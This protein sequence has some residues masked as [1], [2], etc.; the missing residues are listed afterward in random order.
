MAVFFLCVSLASCLK[1]SLNYLPFQT[2]FSHITIP[3]WTFH[4]AWGQDGWMLA[5]VFFFLHFFGQRKSWGPQ[6][7]KNRTRLIFSHLCQTSLVSKES[8]ILQRFCALTQIKND[9]FLLRAGKESQLC[10]WHNEPTRFVF[11]FFILT[12]FCYFLLLHCQQC[13]RIM[14]IVF[15]F[16]TISFLSRIKAGNP[17]PCSLK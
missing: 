17:E 4:E 2:H 12:V 13:P 1:L 5:K 16:H 9:L 8:T 10:L 15:L 11:V 6:K 7:W 14:N 3:L